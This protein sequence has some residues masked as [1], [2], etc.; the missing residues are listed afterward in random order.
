M[1][2]NEKASEIYNTKLEKVILPELKTGLY[3]SKLFYEQEKVRN[4][5]MKKYGERFCE[6]MTDVFMGERSYPS[7]IKKLITKK[8]KN[9][10]F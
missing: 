3:L 6:A 10:I 8:I 9:A 4:F 7:D 1:L 5:L 2:N